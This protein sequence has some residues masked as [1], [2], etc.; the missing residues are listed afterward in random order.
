MYADLLGRE[1]GR[2]RDRARVMPSRASTCRPTIAYDARYPTRRTCFFGAFIDSRECAGPCPMQCLQWGRRE[3][4]ALA[5]KRLRENRCDPRPALAL[6]LYR[7][8]HS[9]AI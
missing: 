2:T 6:R 7:L 1:H 4:D 9:S 8:L 5:P 3:D